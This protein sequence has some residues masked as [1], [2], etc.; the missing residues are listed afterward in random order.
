[1]PGEIDFCEPFDF[2][3]ETRGTELID[4]TGDGQ[5]DCFRPVTTPPP[6]GDGDGDGNGNGNGNG[7]GG[8]GGGDG[9]QPQ[10][11]TPGFTLPPRPED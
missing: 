6:E 5:V 8:R 4:S 11:T 10:P 3:G 1:V 7:R 9:N 2:G